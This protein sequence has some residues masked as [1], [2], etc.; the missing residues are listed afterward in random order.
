MRDVDRAL[1]VTI[2]RKEKI[3]LVFASPAMREK[4]LSEL[5]EC[6]EFASAGKCI[7]VSYSE[8]NS[9]L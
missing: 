7:S 1:Q 8:L 5:Y 6:I 9:F 2:L 3:V 4:V